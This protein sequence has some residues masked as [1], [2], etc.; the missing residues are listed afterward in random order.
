MEKINKIGFKQIIV[1]ISII[2]LIVIVLPLVLY[3][4]NFNDGLSSDATDWAEFGGYIGGVSGT[5]LSLIAVFFSLLSI[6]YSLQIAEKVQN[7]EVSM[8]H[9]LNKPY[10]FLDMH[11]G[12]K[13]TVITLCN[14][15]NGPLIITKWYLECNNQTYRNFEI[16]L[17]EKKVDKFFD[18]NYIDILHNTSPKPILAPNSTKILFKIEPKGY[19]PSVFEFFQE[20]CRKQFENGYLIFEYEDMFENKYTFR[21]SLDFLKK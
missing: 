17:S 9:S 21:Q 15:G 12:P 20:K 5:F 18:F 6:Y 19:D 7:T 4:C 2:I 8:I 11:K 13:K 10:P 3:F 1:P 16:L 14:H